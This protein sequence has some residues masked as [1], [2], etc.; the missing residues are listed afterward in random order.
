MM[1]AICLVTVG[2]LLAA[3]EPSKEQI[4]RVSE[5][6]PPGCKVRNIGPYGDVRHL[7]IVICEGRPTRSVEY[8]YPVGKTSHDVTV[9]Q[10]GEPR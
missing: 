7:V 4:E 5:A 2:L 9:L 3:C 10:I 8:N 6:L 1:R